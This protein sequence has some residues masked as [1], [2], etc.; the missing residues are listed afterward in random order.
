MVFAG[1]PLDPALAQLAAQLGVAQR[2]VEVVDASNEQLEALYNGALALMFPSRFEGFGW[3]IV[4]AQA[5]G[6]PVIC[7]DREPF[8]EVAGGAAIHCDADDAA[9]FGRA[10][11]R[12]AAGEGRDDLV[13]R[14]LENAARFARPAMIARFVA[15]YE[16]VAGRA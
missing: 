4:E 5:C 9:A 1:A 11:L 3:P 8:P 15:I 13:H 14:G 12:L 10:I 16:R 2:V 6:C 7:S